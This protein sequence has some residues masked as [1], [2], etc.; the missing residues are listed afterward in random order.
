MTTQLKPTRYTAVP[1]KTGNR[2]QMAIYQDG[3]NFLCWAVPGVG[4]PTRAACLEDYSKRQPSERGAGM[5]GELA[6]LL[7]E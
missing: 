5:P 4:F 2:W 1:V 6:V 3:D 7:K